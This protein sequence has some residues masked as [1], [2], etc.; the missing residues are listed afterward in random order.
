MKK[1]N[2]V[3]LFSDQHNANVLGCYGNMEKH[4]IYNPA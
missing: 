4:F 3:L 1:P 2:V